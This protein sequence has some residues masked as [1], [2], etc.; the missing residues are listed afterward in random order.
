MAK[1]NLEDIKKIGIAGTGTMGATIAQIFAQYGYEVVL[2]DC[3]QEGLVRGISIIRNNQ[4][5]L[6]SQG[7]LN[8]NEAKQAFTKMVLTNDMKDLKKVDLLIECIVEKIDVKQNFF[9]QITDVIGK[10]A[11]LTTNTSGLS[12]QNR[13]KNNEQG[14][15]CR[16]AL[17]ESPTSYPLSRDYQR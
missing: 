16:D 15:I 7:M 6:I 17:V 14:Q 1:L 5:N 11:L 10:K 2:Y 13:F 8:E 9:E 4:N 3:A 12:R